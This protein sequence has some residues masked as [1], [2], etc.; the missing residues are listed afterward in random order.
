VA[1]VED[2]WAWVDSE[3]G[4]LMSNLSEKEEGSRLKGNLVRKGDEG[5]ERK[6][7]RR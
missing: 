1:V 5:K 4:L 3:G 6:D 2:G 7:L